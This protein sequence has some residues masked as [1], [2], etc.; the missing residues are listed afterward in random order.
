MAGKLPRGERAF[1][2]W[3]APRCI[4]AAVTASTFAAGLVAARVSAA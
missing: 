4:V 2:G 1:I 3:M